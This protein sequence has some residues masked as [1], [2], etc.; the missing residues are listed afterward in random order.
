MYTAKIIKSDDVLWK[1]NP[2]DC[3]ERP[4]LQWTDPP[5][6][7]QLYRSLREEPIFAPYCWIHLPYYSLLLPHSFFDLPGQ[8][9]TTYCSPGIL[10][11]FSTE[12]AKAATPVDWA[13]TEC[14]AS[15][16]Y[17]QPLL[18]S[19]THTVYTNQSPVFLCNLYSC[20]WLSFSRVP[21]WYTQPSWVEGFLLLHYLHCNVLPHHKHKSNTATQP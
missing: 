20:Y 17:R 2:T 18:H 21:D 9:E 7:T 15:P 12:A 13:A 1:E 3:G 11:A 5:A 14:E 8:A 4:S 6:V 16:E 10:Q 19:P